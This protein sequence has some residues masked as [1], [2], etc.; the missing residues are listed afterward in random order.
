MQ[1]NCKFTAVTERVSKVLT[2]LLWR[3]T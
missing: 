2:T 3:K 1:Q